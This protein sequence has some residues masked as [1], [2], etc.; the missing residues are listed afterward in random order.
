MRRSV[1]RRP[2]WP[3]GQPAE[4]EQL[5]RA[6]LAEAED[7]GNTFF[8]ERV[9]SF[10]ARLALASDD[11]DGATQWLAGVPITRQGITGFDIEDARLTRARVLV[12]WATSGDLDPDEAAAAVDHA[13]A[14]AAAR[15]M[16]FSLVQ[17]LAL[18]AVVERLRGELQRAAGS[19]AR[20]LELGGLGRFTRTFID[21]GPPLTALL[22]ELMHQGELAP[23]GRRVLMACRA[24]SAGT[25]LDRP[26]AAESVVPLSRRPS[27][28]AAE[29]SV[30]AALTWRELDVL[31]LMDGHLSN[32]EITRLLGLDDATVLQADEWGML[33]TEDRE[34]PPSE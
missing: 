14:A 34:T 6:E 30:A 9:R 25:V 18:R 29:P 11:L 24:A 3:G 32:E 2:S 27:R 33:G 16:T 5:G 7:A 13:I 28:D 10:V 20:A 26:S 15:H 23:G 22:A 21:L 12:A 17:G 8:V 31:A 19:L 1:W 4:A